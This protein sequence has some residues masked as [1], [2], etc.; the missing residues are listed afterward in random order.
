MHQQFMYKKTTP[1]PFP[2]PTPI[3]TT[4]HAL[5]LILARLSTSRIAQTRYHTAQRRT[6]IY[7]VAIVLPNLVSGEIVAAAPSEAVR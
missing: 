5:I 4:K 2:Q 6:E 3:H 1:D 7:P